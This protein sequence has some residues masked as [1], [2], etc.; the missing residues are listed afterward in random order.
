M[1][2][3][4]LIPI[5]ML[6][7]AFLFSSCGGSGNS[8]RKDTVSIKAT[9]AAAVEINGKTM[10][11]QKCAACHGSDGTAGIANAANLRITKLDS[12]AVVNTISKGKNNMPAFGSQLTPEEIKSIAGYVMTLRK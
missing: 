2:G 3:N 8:D 10:F 4:T 7:A 6:L 1:K 11:E 9:E 5:Y 12:I